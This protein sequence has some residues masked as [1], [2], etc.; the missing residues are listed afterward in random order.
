MPHSRRQV[1]NTLH[2]F[3]KSRKDIWDGN[4]LWKISGGQDETTYACERMSQLSE[5]YGMAAGAE[6]SWALASM[7]DRLACVCASLARGDPESVAKASVPAYMHRLYEI[8]WILMRAASGFG[9]RTRTRRR[10]GVDGARASLDSLFSKAVIEGSSARSVSEATARAVETAEGLRVLS[11]TLS[12][13]LCG[14]F[15]TCARRPLPS[16]RARVATLGDADF[17]AVASSMPTDIPIMSAALVEYAAAL[18]DDG[19]VPHLVELCGG[20]KRWALRVDRAKTLMDAVRAGL[21]THWTP[22]AALL[23]ILSR[24]SLADALRRVHRRAACVPA[25]SNPRPPLLQLD[26]ALTAA[27]ADAAAGEH[28]PVD[29][30]A[31]AAALSLVAGDASALSCLVQTQLDAIAAAAAAA[32]QD[33]LVRVMGPSLQSPTFVTRSLLLCSGCGALKNFVV[34]RQADGRVV[35]A[36]AG[37][38]AVAAP[39]P[40]DD[41]PRPRCVES[42]AC[43]P[44]RL[45]QVAFEAQGRIAVVGERGVTISTCCGV[46]CST[47]ALTPAA[48][49]EWRCLNCV[50][51]MTK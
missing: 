12:R 1:E 38:P 41:E 36:A 42:P 26:A 5:A 39:N 14:G 8:S 23:H 37:H 2:S 48:H 13:A 10:R 33:S 47:N 16:T 25:L 27:G 18:V 46:L 35:L 49:G 21:D 32:R 3:F 29:E 28:M 45:R 6:V 19:H 11:H 15:K 51:E 34:A 40:L 43:A 50:D 17:H 24:S 31:A 7:H 4:R 20:A 22:D 44:A 9:A 30:E